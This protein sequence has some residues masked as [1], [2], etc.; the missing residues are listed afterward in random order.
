MKLQAK[1][2]MFE[3]VG[4]EFCWRRPARVGYA[5]AEHYVRLQKRHANFILSQANAK[6]AV[7]VVF[8]DGNGGHYS[9]CTL[10]G[11]PRCADGRYGA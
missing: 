10:P 5:Q 2:Q 4:K 7:P 11:I 1:L 8:G 9:A 3:A 6:I